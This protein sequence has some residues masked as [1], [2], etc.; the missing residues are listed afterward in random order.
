MKS[1]IVK[2]LLTAAATTASPEIGKT[3]IDYIDEKTG[4]VL[5]ILMGVVSVVGIY[6]VIKNIA[7]L[8]TAVGER[9]ATTMKTAGLGLAGG[10]VMAGISVILAVLGFTV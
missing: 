9:D 7:E 6:I 5:G 4:M 8:A 3:G 1:I 10:I 2:K